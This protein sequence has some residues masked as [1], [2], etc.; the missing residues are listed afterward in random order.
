MKCS[1]AGLALPSC[2]IG[3]VSRQFE[4]DSLPSRE[5]QVSDRR[6]QRTTKELQIQKE[7]FGRRKETAA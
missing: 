1:F 6:I 5:G 3:S 4:R 7:F 2:S